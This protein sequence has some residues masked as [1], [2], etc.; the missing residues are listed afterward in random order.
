M[1]ENNKAVFDALRECRNACAA[2]MRVLYDHGLT[3][4]F[5]AEAKKAGI[6]NGFGKRAD[7]ILSMVVGLD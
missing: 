2:A 6:K 4:E 1:S 3:D 7:A 5:L